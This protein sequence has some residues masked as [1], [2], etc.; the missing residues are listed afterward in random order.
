MSTLLPWAAF[1]LFV[2]AMLVLDLGVFHRRGHAIGVR[3]AAGWSAVWVILALAFNAAVYFW[4]GWQPAV[5]FFTGYLL[6]KSLSLDNLFVFALIFRCT[7]VPAQ[8]QHRVLFWGVWGAIVMRGIFILAGVE[9]VSHFHWFLYVFGIFLLISG[10]NLLR[11]PRR[12][13]D[14]ARSLLL[15]LAR[16]FLPVTERF[17]GGAF[18]LQRA[19]RLWATPLFLVLVLTEAA[20]VIFALDSIPAVIAVTQD[21]FIIFTSNVFAILGL[22]SLY[23]LL[24][25]AIVRFRYLHAGLSLVL[26][27]MGAKM[28]LAYRVKIPTGLALLVILAILLSTILASLHAERKT[29]QESAVNP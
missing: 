19:G 27:F 22:R 7:V 23:F 5:Q 1:N 3:E 2:L 12:E 18:F 8:F 24:A 9:L 13:F 10:V 17:E 6:E 11:K 15:R 25:G 16:K 21:P 20:D 29:S 28:V 26:M 14:P 4:R